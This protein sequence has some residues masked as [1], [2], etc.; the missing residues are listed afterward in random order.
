MRVQQ[1]KSYLPTQWSRKKKVYLAEAVPLFLKKKS[2]AAPAV[3]TAKRQIYRTGRY[4]LRTAG[5]F[6]VF[7]HAEKNRVLGGDI[8]KS[9][10]F[11]WR[12]LGISP[13]AWVT[14]NK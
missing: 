3:I 6:A 7:T 13:L 9:G 4:N 11:A 8:F 14:F 12:Q 1:E 2:P 5:S 10:S